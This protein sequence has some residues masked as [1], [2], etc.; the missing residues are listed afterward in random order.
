MAPTMTLEL[1]RRLMTDNMG[2][3]QSIALRYRDRG[4]SREDLVGEGSLGLVEA[5]RRYDPG[6]GVRFTTYA[7]Y[8]IRRAILRALAAAQTPVHVPHTRRALVRALREAERTL[9]LELGREVHSDEIRARLR[10]G[11]REMDALRGAKGPA[12]SLSRPV[13]DRGDVTL[14]ELLPA[15]EHGNPERAMERRDARRRIRRAMARLDAEDRAILSRRFGLDGGAGETLTEI[16][17]AL[18]MTRQG[19][20]LREQRAL[21]RLRRHMLQ[22]VSRPRFSCSRAG[23][24]AAA[25]R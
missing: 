22:P 2:F 5:A 12:L 7:V 4:L 24:A 23:R 15:G 18:R 10:V 13:G 3:V 19:A 9:P 1:R 25:S 8:W 14:G 20:R 16:G 6:R 21:L 17:A 11:H